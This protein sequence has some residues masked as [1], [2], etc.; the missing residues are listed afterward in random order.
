MIVRGAAVFAL[1]LV[2]AGCATT[3]PRPADLTTVGVAEAALRAASRE[4]GAG[5]SLRMRK[6]QPAAATAIARTA[7]RMR[8]A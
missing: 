3:T 1:V 5:A 4:T 8:W 2:A 7:A 6:Y